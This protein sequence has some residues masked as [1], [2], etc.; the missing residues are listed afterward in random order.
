[1]VTKYRSR[2]G[3][4][5]GT[6]KKKAKPKARARKTKVVPKTDEFEG[7]IIPEVAEMDVGGQVVG[8]TGGSIRTGGS[9]GTGGSVS[10]GGSIT[11]P[12]Q[13]DGM[14]YS[15]MIHT[16]GHMDNSEYHTLQGLASAF[17]P[18][19]AHPLKRSYMALL[20][21]SF[22]HPPGISEVATMDILKS[23]NGRELAS[24]LHSEFGEAQK[25]KQVGGGLFSSLKN[26]FKK[27]LSGLGKGL[28]G[29]LHIGK[30]AS[31]AL[32]RGKDIARILQGPVAQ[33]APGLS[34]ALEKGIGL[35][36]KAEHGIGVGLPV[37]ERATELIN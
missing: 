21:G 15:D 28:R 17:L 35:A 3:A 10:T 24:A 27:G 9:V 7:P 12:S 36:E 22:V 2:V 33:F 5:V 37:L 6:K 4:G 16:L 11:S 20:G 19:I 26:V 32:S 23:P 18:R 25:G 8:A 29:A 30:K 31:S 34:G 14:S 1:M 13:V